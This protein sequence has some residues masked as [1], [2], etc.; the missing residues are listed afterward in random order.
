VCK[1]ILGEQINVA[2]GGANAVESLKR[3]S[4]NLNACGQFELLRKGPP[5]WKPANLTTAGTKVYMATTQ[6]KPFGV[7]YPTCGKLSEISKEF[8]LIIKKK[9]FNV[10]QFVKTYQWNLLG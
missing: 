10:T 7:P 9:G 4:Q 2:G 8:E 1:F 6:T 3:T 5:R